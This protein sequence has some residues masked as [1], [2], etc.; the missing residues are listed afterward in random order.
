MKAR[1]PLLA[2]FLWASGCGGDARDGRPGTDSPDPGSGAGGTVERCTACESGQ[3]CCFATGRCYSPDQDPDACAPAPPP[4]RTGDG[5]SSGGGT[6]GESEQKRCSSN[7]HCGDSEFCRPDSDASACVSSGYC[8]P[9]DCSV[10]CVGGSTCT[11]PVC[12]CDGETYETEAD[13]CS[14]GV[15]VV[16][17]AAC[18]EPVADSQPIVIGCAHDGQCPEGESCCAIS[19]RCFE[20]ACE[21]CCAPPPAG[22]TAPC[23]G[24]EHCL[25]GQYCAGEGCGSPGGCVWLRGSGECTGQIQEVCGCNGNSYTNACWAQSDGTRVAHLGPCE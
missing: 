21:G 23:E 14:A 20:T 17:T 22:T 1:V 2:L 9:R 19:G 7:A 8:V 6:L 16:T 18:G 4:T 5:G 3:E 13:A 10:T 12:G 11:R 15:R 25:P 24:N